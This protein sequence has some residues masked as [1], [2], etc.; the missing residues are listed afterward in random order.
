MIRQHVAGGAGIGIRLRVLGDASDFW[1]VLAE[2][3]NPRG[4]VLSFQQGV[5]GSISLI[6]VG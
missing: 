6:S 3:Q 4:D 1:F 5:I 2:N